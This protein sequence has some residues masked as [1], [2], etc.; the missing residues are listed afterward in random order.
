MNNRK[1]KETITKFFQEKKLPN[2]HFNAIISVLFILLLNFS[3]VTI[4]S[5]TENCICIHHHHHHHHHHCQ[6]A[7]KSHIAKH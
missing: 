5:T 6:Y 2:Y 4:Y 7:I 3:I 1:K